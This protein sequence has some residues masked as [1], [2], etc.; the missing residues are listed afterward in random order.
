MKE[1]NP[2]NYGTRAPMVF[3]PTF[4]FSE[5][6]DR[7]WIEQLGIED[8]SLELKLVP[9]KIENLDKSP[10]TYL[11]LRDLKVL[12]FFHCQQL[13]GF[14]KIEKENLNKDDKKI[15]DHHL[16]KLSTITNHLGQLEVLSSQEK[17][18]REFK[19]FSGSFFHFFLALITDGKKSRKIMTIARDQLTAYKELRT[20]CATP[21][22]DL[23]YLDYFHALIEVGCGNWNKAT[24]IL[25]R[26]LKKHFD[27]KM[28]LVLCQLY[29]HIGMPQVA[30]FI[31]IKYSTQ[32]LSQDK[33]GFARESNKAKLALA[34]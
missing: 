34:A 16:K 20:T 8:S 14:L 19:E 9:S 30:K 32:D 26:A 33:R 7:L 12:F 1:L 21:Y 3:L 4:F 5:P 6:H 31:K 29:I 11:G 2:I 15:R 23:L 22:S 18:L 28:L 25:H 10:L 27:Q 17:E 24:A 13:K